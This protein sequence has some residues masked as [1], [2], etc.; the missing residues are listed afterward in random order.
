MRFG[1]STH[2]F[3][4]APLDRTHLQAVADK[5]FDCIELFATRTHFDYHDAAAAARLGEWLRATGLTLHS[6]HAPITDSLVKGVWGTAYSNAAA[7]AKRRALAVQETEYA[8]KLASVLPYQFL[9][10]HLGVPDEYA[11]PGDNAR[12]AARQSV[13]AFAATAAKHNVKLALEVIPN[14]LSTPEALVR[15]VEQDLDIPEIAICG[16]CMDVGHAHVMGDVPDAIETVAGHLTTTHIHDNDGR[17]DS[18]QMPFDGSLDWASALM[19]FQKVG[20]DD[21]LL[22]ELAGTDDPQRVLERA[23]AARLRFE[24][25]LA[26]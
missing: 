8:I 16:I 24:E 23:R 21:V 19:A 2:L 18:H 3:H 25:I 14:A 11:N 7:D 6:V 9:V 13:E 20:Y 4:D 12:D 10:V 26:S 22:F 17:R 15:L 1:I 5:G